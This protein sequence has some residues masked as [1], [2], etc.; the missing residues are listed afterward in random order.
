VLAMKEQDIQVP[1]LP[2]PEVA[3]VYHGAQAK[4][5]AV[6]LLTALR[7]EGLRAV[8]AYGDRSMKAQ[9]RNVNRSGARYAVILG[10]DELAAGQVTWQDMNAAS[11]D[12]PGVQESLNQADLV[13]IL[14]Q[15]LRQ[16]AA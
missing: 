7:S 3:L 2:T 15:R 4:A 5:R 13:A 16:Q 14:K 1:G 9:M 12:Q 6:E 10:D 8:M 11:P